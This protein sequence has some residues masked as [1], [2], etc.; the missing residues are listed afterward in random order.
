VQY[1]L[2]EMFALEEIGNKVFYMQISRGRSLTGK[3]VQVKRQPYKEKCELLQ[4]IDISA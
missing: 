1:S 3:Y 4:I 2:N